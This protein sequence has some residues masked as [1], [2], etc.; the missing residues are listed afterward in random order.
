MNRG[1]NDVFEA[2]DLIKQAINR[3]GNTIAVACSFGKDSMVV[4]HMALKV[5]PNIKVIFEDTGVEFPET[6]KFKGKIKEKWN[7]RLFESKPIKT[8][9]E[10]IEKYGLPVFRGKGNARGPKCC[11]Y[12][13]ERPALL[14]QRKI[15]VNAILTGLMASESNQRKLTML[16]YDNKKAPIMKKDDVEF[17]AQRWYAKREGVWKYHPLAY[18]NEKQVW[19]YI[20]KNNIP[21]NPVYLKWGGIYKRCG[22][23]P[24]TAYLDWEKKLSKSHP[25]L[26]RLLK[27]KQNPNQTKL[28]V[29][30]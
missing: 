29:G 26:Y 27:S 5:N 17:C 19:D 15:K 10:C 23:L 3:H 13:K 2:E 20:K 6:I 11:H 30:K 9:W 7:L 21:I 22:C 1:L 14:L 24:C 18:W 4:L 25:K 8:F 12:L 16:R 28:K